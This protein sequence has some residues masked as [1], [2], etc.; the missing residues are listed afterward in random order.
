MGIIR[1][2]GRWNWLVAAVLL[3]G[4]SATPELVAQPPPESDVL[5]AGSPW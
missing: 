5:P 1:L 4:F 2:K 3:G